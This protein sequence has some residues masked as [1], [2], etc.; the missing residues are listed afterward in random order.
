[1]P[2]TSHSTRLSLGATSADSNEGLG[3]P[4]SPSLP[5]SQACS[6][7]LVLVWP[8]FFI[9]L[10]RFTKFS[11]H[12]ELE[13]PIRVRLGLCCRI[14]HFAVSYTTEGSGGLLPMPKGHR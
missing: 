10:K 12:L 4:P 8:L 9:S 6:V 11:K 13:L 5:S 14:C 1:M 2:A 3:I 7:G